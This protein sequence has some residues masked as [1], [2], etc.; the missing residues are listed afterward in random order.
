MSTE[1]SFPLD[2]GAEMLESH[3]LNASLSD[4]LEAAME[5]VAELAVEA[6]NDLRLE[7]RCRGVSAVLY[8]KVDEIKGRRR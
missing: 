7:V 2:D 8:A 6:R 5:L 1:V 4:R 3:R